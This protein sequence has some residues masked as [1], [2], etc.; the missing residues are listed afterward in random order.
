MA[1]YWGYLYLS[2]FLSFFLFFSFY[3]YWK[4]FKSDGTEMAPNKQANI[5][6]FVKSNENH[7]LGTGFLFVCKRVE[8]VSDRMSCHCSECSSPNRIK[9]M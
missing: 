9:L 3:C 1:G 8:F 7:E 5:Y 2:F 6:F 4:Y